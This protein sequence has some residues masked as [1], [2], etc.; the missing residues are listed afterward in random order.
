V[1]NLRGKLK[2]AGL[3][4]GFSATAL[5]TPTPSGDLRLQVIKMKAAGFIP[6]SLLDALA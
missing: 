6:K 4:I 5:A 1:I 3:P 2:M